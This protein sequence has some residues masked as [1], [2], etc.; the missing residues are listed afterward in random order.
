MSFTWMPDEPPKVPSSSFVY[1]VRSSCALSSSQKPESQTFLFFC[2]NSSKGFPF[3]S[4]IIFKAPL[5]DW[6][7]PLLVPCFLIVLLYS[8]ALLELLMSH[9]DPPLPLLHSWVLLHKCDHHIEA[10]PGILYTHEGKSWFHGNEKENRVYFRNNIQLENTTGWHWLNCEGNLV[11]WENIM[12][13][14][15]PIELWS[16]H[17]ALYTQWLKFQVV[18]DLWTDRVW[19]YRNL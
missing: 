1:T 15:S 4:K 11:S 6:P 13:H 12:P 19:W 8:P 14:C 2:L 10:C 17:N 16:H 7:H 3:S 5:R 9:M 18:A